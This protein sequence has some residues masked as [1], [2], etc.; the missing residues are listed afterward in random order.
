MGEPRRRGSL[1]RVRLGTEDSMNFEASACG[2]VILPAHSASIGRGPAVVG[3]VLLASFVPGS[4]A[5]VRGQDAESQPPPAPV[6]VDSLVAVAMRESPRLRSLED[7][8]RASLERI[9]QAGALPYPLLTFTAEGTPLSDP[10]PANAMEKR[11]EAGK[12]RE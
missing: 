10:S 6:D 12:E 9:P 7:A 1:A 2:R 11:S 5:P 8:Y 4:L 3:L